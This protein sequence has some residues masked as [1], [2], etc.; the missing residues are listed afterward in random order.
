MTATK[1]RWLPELTGPAK[2]VEMAV[3]A[4]FECLLIASFLQ[5]VLVRSL[6]G[7]AQAEL[8]CLV[9]SWGFSI[10]VG[11]LRFRRWQRTS[12]AESEPPSPAP[13]S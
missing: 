5:F 8:L 1:R 12:R 10:T 11:V 2:T 7:H 9:S 4:A 13:Q 3:V 6:E